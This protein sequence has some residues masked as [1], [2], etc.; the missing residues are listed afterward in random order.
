MYRLDNEMNKSS[1]SSSKPSAKALEAATTIGLANIVKNSEKRP[2]P[3]AFAILA[4]MAAA[5]RRT[6]AEDSLTAPKV[7]Q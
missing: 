2:S 7:G 5:K 1:A 3:Q 4:K 6:V